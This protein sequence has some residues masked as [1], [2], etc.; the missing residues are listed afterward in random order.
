[1]ATQ[2]VSLHDEGGQKQDINDYIMSVV[3]LDGKMKKWRD[4]EKNMVVEKLT[5]KADGM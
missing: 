2:Q 5:A 4:A 3:H 1:L